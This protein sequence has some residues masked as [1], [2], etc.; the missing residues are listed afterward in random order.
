MPRVLLSGPV[1]RLTVNFSPVLN[2]RVRLPALT[3]ARILHGLGRLA[4]S[5]H[6]SPDSH[7][8]PNAETRPSRSAPW[9]KLH[10]TLR[11][12]GKQPAVD[13]AVHSVCHSRQVH[14]NS[15]GPG[16]KTETRVA[17]KRKDAT[18]QRT[19]RYATRRLMQ[20]P[21][22]GFLSVCCGVRLFL[23]CAMTNHFVP[24]HGRAGY[25]C[26]R[27]RPRGLLAVA[28]GV[29]QGQRNHGCFS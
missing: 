29:A 26:S 3:S 25:Q 19:A 15:A 2:N 17:W 12:T 5:K 6:V 24:S 13:G 20:L 22:R 1:S 23:N 10:L 4:H 28:S 16:R 18:L 7:A 8:R 11:S 14:C 21:R 9:S 27:E